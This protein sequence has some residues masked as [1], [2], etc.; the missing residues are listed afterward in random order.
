MVFLVYPVVSVCIV[1][2]H[3]RAILDWVPILANPDILEYSVIDALH[4]KNLLLLR[5][6]RYLTTLMLKTFNK[7]KNVFCLQAV[8]KT[9]VPDTFHIFPSQ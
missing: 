2:K 4:K 6:D 3:Q 7:R 9:M 1:S 5:E 8:R